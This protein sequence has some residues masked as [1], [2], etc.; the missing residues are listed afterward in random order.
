GLVLVGSGWPAAWL[1]VTV[2]ATLSQVTVSSVELDATFPLP[3]G[4]LATPAA[5]DAM[6]V[7]GVVIPVTATVYVVGPPLT[8]PV[9]VPPAVPANVT[10]PVAKPVTGSL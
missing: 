2:G 8:V 3:A 7:P 1:M 9:M 4:S 10:S 5:I 6:T